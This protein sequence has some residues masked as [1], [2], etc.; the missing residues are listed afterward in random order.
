MGEIDEN[1]RT[2]VERSPEKPL[3]EGD[4]LEREAYLEERKTLIEAEGEAS[5]SLDKALITL[6]AGA[7]GL[8]IVF[9]SRIA[10]KPEALPWLYTAWTGFIIAL[11]LILASFLLSQWAF[12]RALAILDDDY[13]NPSEAQKTNGWSVA[14]GWLTSLSGASFVFG[15][16]MLAVFAVKN[17]ST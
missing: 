11:V 10:P 5:Q 3:V 7:F 14:T 16:V 4:A 15:V 9:V 2:T 12:R 13:K 1:P 8:S 6:S 17:L